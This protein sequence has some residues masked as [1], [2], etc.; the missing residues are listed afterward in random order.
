MVMLLH[1][2]RDIVANVP[3]SEEVP[4]KGSMAKPE[5]CVFR[6]GGVCDALAVRPLRLFR[7]IRRHQQNT[8]VVEQPRKKRRRL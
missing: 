6:L 3:K 4:S 2:Q 7:K 1:R 8:H 5:R